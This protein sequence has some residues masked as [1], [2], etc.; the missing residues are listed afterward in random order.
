MIND[1]PAMQ[2]TWIRSLGWEDIWRREWQ[3]T[4]VFLPGEFHGQRSLV[5]YTVNGVTKSWTWLSDYQGLWLVCYFYWNC[6]S[7]TYIHYYLQEYLLRLDQSLFLFP[8]S[9]PTYQLIQFNPTVNCCLILSLL[10]WIH[11]CL[12]IRLFP[13]S[14]VCLLHKKPLINMC[15]Q[16]W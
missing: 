1:L 15:W 9:W 2:E 8:S 10:W 7:P 6:S 13:I 11:V 3:P 5:C 14:R 4:P 12:C 16:I